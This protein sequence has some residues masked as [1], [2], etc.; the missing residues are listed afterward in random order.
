LNDIILQ[1]INLI[2]G[3]PCVLFREYFCDTQR[4]R[5]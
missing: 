1:E 5:Q 3:S 4:R 2:F